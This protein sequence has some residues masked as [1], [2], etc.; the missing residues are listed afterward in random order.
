MQDKPLVYIAI[1]NWNSF[2]ETSE[3]IEAC[4]QLDYSNF[5]ILILDNGSK[6]GSA[7]KLAERFPE[8]EFIQTGANLG[9]AAGNNIGIRYAIA[10]C[11]EYVWI[12]NPDA[13]VDKGTLSTMI[14]VLAKCPSIGI[15]GPR[16]IHGQEPSSFL[17][18]GMSI[19]PDK[20]YQWR[21]NVIDSASKAEQ[22]ALHDVDCVSGCS[23]LIRSGLF[24]SIGLFREDFFLYYED[25]EFCYR[26]RDHGWRTIICPETAVRH[27][28]HVQVKKQ[29]TGFR[30]ERSRIIL[31]RI[32][33]N[34]TLNNLITEQS[35]ELF[36]TALRQ[37]RPLKA[38]LLLLHISLGILYGLLKPRKAVPKL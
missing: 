7:E 33:G 5:R 27:D 6:D 12:L 23:M 25:V 28:K 15:C 31:A 19:D 24:H 17:F 9:Y 29:S 26:A 35:M 21:F 22:E 38:S 4:R 2:S 32:C 13:L 20:G 10:K 18:D 16:V 8:T 37:L 11:S 3:C 30:V 36:L 34:C 14:D 1:L